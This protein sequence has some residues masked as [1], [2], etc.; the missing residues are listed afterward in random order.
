MSFKG[1][2]TYVKFI[3]ENYK[4]LMK[5]ILKYTNKWKDILCLWIEV[6][7]KVKIFILPKVI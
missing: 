3:G 2:S 5:E 6:I 7:N 1:E 4:T